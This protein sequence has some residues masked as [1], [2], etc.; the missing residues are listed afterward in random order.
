MI[1]KTKK[2]SKHQL[3][4]YTS[5]TPAGSVLKVNLKNE[6]IS[7]PFER[8]MI[9]TKGTIHFDYSGEGCIVLMNLSN[10]DF[11]INDSERICKMVIDKHEKDE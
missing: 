3:P 2:R 1:I 9:N 11:V 8:V 10:K 7:K 5:D 4:K 6:V